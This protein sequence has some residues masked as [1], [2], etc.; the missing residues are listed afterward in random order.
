M[1]EV[2]EEQETVEEV[3]QTQPSSTEEQLDVDLDESVEGT[4][5]TELEQAISAF[6]RQNQDQMFSVADFGHEMAVHVVE[7][8]DS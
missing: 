4:T 8:S 7:M 5:L 3:V 6:A 2:F 1:E